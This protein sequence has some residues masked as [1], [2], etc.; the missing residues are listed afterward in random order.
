MRARVGNT[1]A[2]RL[3]HLLTRPHLHALLP[4]GRTHAAPQRPAPGRTPS[5]LPLLCSP[6]SHGSQYSWQKYIS[7]GVDAP[8]ASTLA[9]CQLHPINSTMF[10]Q[11][12][13]EGGAQ[14]AGG[15]ALLTTA[16]DQHSWRGQA[17]YGRAAPGTTRT[18]PPRSPRSSPAPFCQPRLAGHACAPVPQLAHQLDLLHKQLHLLSVLQQ[19]KPGAGATAWYQLR[20]A[21][22][23]EA[24]PGT[25][26]S[27]KAAAGPPAALAAALAAAAGACTQQPAGRQAAASEQQTRS[28]QLASRATA[29]RAVRGAAS[30]P[31]P[32]ARRGPPWSPGPPWGSPL[33]GKARLAAPWRT[34]LRPGAAAG[35]AGAGRVV[36][37]LACS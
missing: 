9:G 27:Y 23:E 4:C 8:L 17:P 29:P 34:L 3:L 6:P 13:T 5:Q 22:A 28:Q 16:Q 18:P 21:V 14:G 31:P 24:G 33:L 25:S 12:D 37:G 20:V 7:L 10:L 2:R 30:S 11:R 32:R 36:S 35:E 1:G 15:P 19:R 26:S